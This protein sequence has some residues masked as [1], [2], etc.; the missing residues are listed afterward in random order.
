MFTETMRAVHSD[1]ITSLLTSLG[2]LDGVNSGEFKCSVCGEPVTVESISCIYPEND[3]VMLLCDK[4]N[5]VEE[6]F[7]RRAQGDA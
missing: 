5:C 7:D 2:I 4:T 3:Q 6:L 1:D